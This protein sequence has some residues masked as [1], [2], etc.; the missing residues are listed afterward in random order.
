MPDNSELQEIQKVSRNNWRLHFRSE[1][2]LHSGIIMDVPKQY[3][4]SVLDLEFG[5]Y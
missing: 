2:L 3:L 4:Q 1:G 5:V